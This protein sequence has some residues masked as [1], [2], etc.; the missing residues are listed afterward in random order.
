VASHGPPAAWPVR[1]RPEWFAGLPV[2]VAGLGRSGRSAARQLAEAGADVLACDDAPEVDAGELAAFGVK[3]YLGPGGPELLDG[4]ALL[5][6]A[7]GLPE[8]HPLIKAALAAGV[9][10]WSEIEL[11]ARV[12]TM[13]LV[14]VTGTNG[15]TTTT[16]LA[17]AMLTASGLHAVAAGNVGLPLIEA[18][19][20]RHPPEAVVVELSSFQ[21]RFT[22]TLHLH[23]GAWLNFAPDHLDWH[24]DLA[25]YAEAKA[26]I[27]ANQG[28]DDWSLYAADDPVVAAHGQ[29]APGTGVPFTVGLPAPGGLGLEAGV[30]LSRIPGHDG[31]LWRAAA[32]RLP[33]RHNLA[34]AIAASGV[35][36]ALGAHPAGMA[37]AVAAFRPGPHR[38]ATVG[39]VRGVAFVNDS[40]ATN[41]HAAARALAAFPRVVW[42]AGGR[43]KGLSFDQLVDDALDR[44]VGVVLVGEAADELA[45]A[46]ELAGYPGPVVRAASIG[47]AVT[48]GFGLADPGDTV[49]LAPACASHDMFSGYAERGLA[50]EAAVGRLAARHHPEGGGHGGA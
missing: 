28:P 29:R 27:W 24:P 46:L 20:D 14:G 32:L 42:I 16:E 5:V 12:A 4:R 43:N 1:C 10:V 15:K 17:A 7:P 22:W 41:P 26:T 13:P 30:A 9:P 21:L 31:G 36:L 3:T 33:G 6:V 8:A 45:A 49:L 39:E 19:L 25:A 44:L 40:K 37:R 35:A 48:V 11:A 47:E 34:N 38:L 2:L 50:F 18:V 23:A